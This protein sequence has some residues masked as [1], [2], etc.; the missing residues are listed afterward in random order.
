MESLQMIKTKSD[1][2]YSQRAVVSNYLG[3]YRI[4]LVSGYKDAAEIIKNNVFIDGE[5]VE[6]QGGFLS[7]DLIRM[8]PFVDALNKAE[9]LD[10]I[11]CF[12][13]KLPEIR[14]KLKDK[15]H[16]TEFTLS[17]YSFIDDMHYSNQ[18]HKSYFGLKKVNR[19]YYS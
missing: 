10:P 2:P 11:K 6:F 3:C 18:T 12:E 5:L 8:I 15:V 17:V 1:K 16:D 13:E 4:I 7:S 14:K 9:G 19:E